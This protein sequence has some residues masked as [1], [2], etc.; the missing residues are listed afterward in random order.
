MTTPDVTCCADLA[1]LM[2]TR[3]FKALCDPTRIAILV[4]LA[5]AG[6]AQTVGQIANHSP[7]D[8]SVV[9][10]HLAVL[11]DAEIVE[12]T[13]NGKEVYYQVRYRALAETLRTMANAI[14]TCCPSER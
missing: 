5:E 1:G 8:L 2:E 4:G 7:V 13:R 12:G 3:L 11:R 6:D 14:E 9:S 10:R